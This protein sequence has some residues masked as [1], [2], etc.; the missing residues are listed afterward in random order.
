M[1]VEGCRF[2]LYLSYICMCVFVVSCNAGVF[3]K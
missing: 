2:K 1:Q 3:V